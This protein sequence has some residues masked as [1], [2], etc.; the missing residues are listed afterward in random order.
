MSRALAVRTPISSDMIDYVRAQKHIVKEAADSIFI[1][2]RDLELQVLLY[3]PRLM[4][5]YG[6]PYPDDNTFANEIRR[7]IE[8][9][10]NRVNPY[11]NWRSDPSTP[12]THPREAN[13]VEVPEEEVHIIHERFH[14]LSSYRPDSISFG[15]ETCKEKRL[16]SLVTLSPFDLD[17]VT[18]KLT[19]GV[20]KSNVL[21]VSRVFCFD[22]VPSNTVSYMMGQMYK[23]IRLIQPDVKMLLSYINPNLAF[24]GASLKAWYNPINW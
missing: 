3:L 10:R 19:D 21:V 18:H 11:A 12:L 9:I 15:L 6:R 2:E 5:D 1:T 4:H 7:L 23:Q 13:F 24:T 22:W 16:A 14:Y 8:L 17:H 20:N